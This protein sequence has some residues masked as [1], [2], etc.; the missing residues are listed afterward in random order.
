M[1]S[2][3]WTAVAPAW[4]T[5]PLSAVQATD[6]I[7]LVVVLGI[8][9]ALRLVF[10]TGF[11]GSDE[12]TYVETAVNIVAGDWHASNYIG[13]TRYGMNLPVAL[14][15][16]LF[17]L[18]EASA[19]LWPFLCSVGEVALVFVIARWLWSTRA[20]VV[21]AL[22]I[23]LL[24]L[25][26]HFAGRMMADPA[27][28][29]FLTLSAALVLRAASSK[30]WL[31]FLAAGLAWGGVF[32]VKEA[33]GLLYAPVFVLLSVYLNRINSRQLWLFLGMGFA[34]AANCALMFFVADN[35][36][37]VFAV[38]KRAVVKIAGITTLSES[39]WF[40]LR[41]LLL[42]IRHTFLLGLLAMAGGILYA[43]RLFQDKETDHN[44]QFVVMWVLLLVGMFSFAVVSFSPVKFVM[45]QTNYMLIFVGPMALL[46]GWFLAE[47]PRRIFVPLVALTVTGSLV[48]AA[49]EQQSIAVFTANSKATYSFVRDQPNTFLVGTTNNERAI[50]FYSLMENRLE[51]RDRMMSF[52]EMA[53][54]NLA[55]SPV[56]TANRLAGK[57]V[58]AL[59]DLQTIDWG[60]NLGGIRQLSDVPKCWTSMGTLAPAPLGS[61]SWVVTGLVALGNAFPASL[62]RRYLSAL[63]PVAVPAPAHLFKVS[64]S[65]LTDADRM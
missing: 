2:P 25:H 13:A 23:A 48:L 26:V 4:R 16:Y 40:Y 15:I 36:L 10:F 18:S 20:A 43:K 51:L 38:M 7:G 1:N 37:H 32:W 55:N 53:N 39:P 54:L 8:A 33:V 11:F 58:F 47:L 21:S 63:Q 42:D 19:N 29:F 56:A 49:L 35:P 14:F 22:L 64:R 30:Y 59:V 34:V 52:G 65:C 17:G 12:V 5:A 27:L 45:K 31:T 60:N 61:G 9:T 28:A 44:T 24:P 3:Q 50:N 6:W 57:D 41:Y 46:A 62:Q